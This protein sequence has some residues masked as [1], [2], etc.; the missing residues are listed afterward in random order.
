[1]QGITAWNWNN[2]AINMQLIRERSNK[3][4]VAR[5]KNE[6]AEDIREFIKNGGKI[7][8]LESPCVSH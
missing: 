7:K 2:Q 6:L 8:K 1:M 3:K 5:V 4:T